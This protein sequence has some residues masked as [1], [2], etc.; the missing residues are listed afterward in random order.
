LSG[1]SLS[2]AQGTYNPIYP[3]E[4]IIQRCP[5]EYIRR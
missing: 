3:R 4:L 1:D 5:S 2:M